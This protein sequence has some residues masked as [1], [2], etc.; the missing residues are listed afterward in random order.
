V[1]PH[2]VPRPFHPD[3][4]DATFFRRFEEPGN[5]AALNDRATVIVA[6]RSVQ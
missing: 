6:S 2:F 3:D 5:G 1:Q 4:T